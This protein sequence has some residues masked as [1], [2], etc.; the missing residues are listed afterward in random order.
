MRSIYSQKIIAKVV[1]AFIMVFYCCCSFAQGYKL[2]G[3]IKGVGDGWAFVRHRQTGK[4]DS[5]QIQA[6]HFFLS[7]SLT[8][9]EFCTF[10]FSANGIKDYFL[11]FFLEKGEF[12][13]TA[14]KDSLNDISI[15]FTGSPVENEFQDF[16]RQVS[17]VNRRRYQ[18]ARAEKELAQLARRY[19]LKHPG[20]YVSAFA[21][22]S[23]ENNLAELSGLYGR[24][25]SE[26]QRS[27]YGQLINNKISHH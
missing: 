5:C 13:M 11:S 16:Q 1:F 23:Y 19:A 20:S 8:K 15:T 27:Y 12:N 26:I 3:K 25:A 18:E 14:S 7:G 9:P 10:G 2:H 4:T 24:L 22:A 17:R 6:G 21:L